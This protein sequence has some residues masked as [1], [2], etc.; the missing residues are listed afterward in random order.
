LAM[1]GSWLALAASGHAALQPLRDIDTPSGAAF[2]ADWLAGLCAGEGMS[3]EPAD[4]SAIWDSILALASAPAPERTLTGLCLLLQSPRLKAALLPF[5]LEGPHGRLLDG[6][7]DALEFSG[8]ACFEMEELMQSPAAVGPVLTYLFHRLDERF[9][10]RPTLLLLDE[11]WVYLDHPVFAPQLR[12]WLKT[13]RKKNVAVVFATQSLADIER[14]AIAPAIIDACPVRIF[15][16]NERALE[17]VQAA[18]YSRFGLNG[19]EVS[20]ISE[21]VPKQDYYYTSPMGNRLFELGLGPVGLAFCGAS[22]PEDQARIAAAL[23]APG[24]GGFAGDFL[25]AQGLDW[26][27]DLLPAWPGAGT[28]HQPSPKV[29]FANETS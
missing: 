26:A 19:R 28:G 23:S 22:S 8:L 4:K 2:A 3:L 7:T 16:P 14:S 10:G 12:D 21:A 13:L 11:A 29:E 15:L 25:R 9:D 6:D 18:T 20:L 5:T 27:A 24:E 17:P 1:G